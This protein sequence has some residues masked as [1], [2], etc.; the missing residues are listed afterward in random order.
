MEELFNN[1]SFRLSQTGIG[2]LRDQNMT[3]PAV[4][5]SVLPPLNIVQSYNHNNQNEVTDFTLFN[6]TGFICSLCI[7]DI[8]VHISVNVMD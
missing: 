6:N 8:R 7:V 3:D 5:N 4:T 2:E 1:C